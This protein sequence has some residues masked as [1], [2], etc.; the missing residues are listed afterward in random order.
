MLDTDLHK[1]S[2]LLD[3]ETELTVE[4][5]VG[6]E[7]A[8]DIRELKQWLSPPWEMA[9]LTSINVEM[10]DNGCFF[11]HA[12]EFALPKLKKIHVQ[13][14][15]FTEPCST[16]I[17]L[18][19]EKS[20]DIEEATFEG[21]TKSFQSLVDALHPSLR[22]LQIVSKSSDE[23]NEI[24]LDFPSLEFLQLTYWSDCQSWTQM[25]LLRKIVLEK[26]HLTDE[27]KFDAFKAKCPNA[28]YVYAGSRTINLSI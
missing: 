15:D 4:H 20:P 2:K 22:R 10:G 23:S 26:T 13:R 19:K 7:R 6:M 28:D 8:L 16:C 27:F 12:A 17:K 9:H 3:S 21:K 18:L 5:F 14:I 1:A 24:I 25:P 11:V